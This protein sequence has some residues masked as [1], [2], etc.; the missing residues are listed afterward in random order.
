[1][2][3]PI[4]FL[5]FSISLIFSIF[6]TF[7]ND[8]V[9]IQTSLFTQKFG[10][11]ESCLTDGTGLLQVPLEA[12]WIYQSGNKS[13]SAIVGKSVKRSQLSYCQD[14]PGKCKMRLPDNGK[15]FELTFCQAWLLARYIQVVAV[16]FGVAAWITW[17]FSSFINLMKQFALL[18]I[19]LY[20][21]TQVINMQL[22]QH[23]RENDIFLI[24][25]LYG[26]SFSALNAAWGLGVIVAVTL[27]VSIIMKR[28]QQQVAFLYVAIP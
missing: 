20:S 8:F 10:I 1:M 6:A 24:G 28:Q 21:V 16:A 14:F 23:I 2:M 5:I 22:F 25:G 4:A 18:L 13:S 12:S 26:Y 3:E 9:R 19:T 15:S 27:I 7:S 17:I 11:F